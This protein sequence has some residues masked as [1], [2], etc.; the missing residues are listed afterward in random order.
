MQATADKLDDADELDETN[1]LGLLS[2]TIKGNKVSNP[3]FTQPNTAGTGPASWSGTN[4]PAGST[5]WSSGSASITGSGG[6]VLASGSPSWTKATRSRSPPARRSTSSSAFAR[7]G[8]RRRPATGLVYL[9]ALGQVV[10]TVRLVTAPLR[11]SASRRSN[12]R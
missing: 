6:S 9:G 8:S 12:R 7:A 2:F 3:S 11:P 1:N 5:S 4:T 10:Q